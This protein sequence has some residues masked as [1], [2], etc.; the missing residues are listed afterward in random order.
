M[1]KYEK[2]IEICFW[3]T[4]ILNLIN[5]IL[6]FPFYILGITKFPLIFSIYSSIISIILIICFILLIR[7]A[8]T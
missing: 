4:S 7:T 5:V 8:K 3:I 2:I 6:Y 1:S